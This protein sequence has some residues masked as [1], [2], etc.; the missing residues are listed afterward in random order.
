MIGTHL[1]CFAT[2]IG[3]TCQV[4]K[5]VELWEKHEGSSASSKVA[6]PA[7]ASDFEGGS[8]PKARIAKQ[9]KTLGLKRGALSQG[10]VCPR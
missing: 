9:L 8:M 1:A 2:L 7:I 3:W 10:Q 4:E 5:L 6:L